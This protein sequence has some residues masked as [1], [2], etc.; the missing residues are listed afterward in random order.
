MRR[1]N[2]Q[3]KIWP[4]NHPRFSNYRKHVRLNVRNVKEKKKSEIFSTVQNCQQFGWGLRIVLNPIKN[5]S[6]KWCQ[7]KLTSGSDYC[8]GFMMLLEMASKSQVILNSIK[9]KIEI[10]KIVNF[11]S[12]NAHGNMSEYM[13]IF[14]S[15]MI[16]TNGTFICMFGFPFLE[17]SFNYRSVENHRRS[18]IFFSLNE[19]KNSFCSTKCDHTRNQCF[20]WEKCW[21]RLICIVWLNIFSLIFTPLSAPVHVIQLLFS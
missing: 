16:N 9:S 14:S 10:I 15:C 11:E 8:R 3:S 5:I 7:S 12:S 20:K 4:A 21:I 18:F 6:S 2:V 17:F 1:L 13:C 19:F